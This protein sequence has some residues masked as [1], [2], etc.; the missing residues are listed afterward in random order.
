VE[1]PRWLA[2]QSRTEVFGPYSLKSINQNYSYVDGWRY[3][4]NEE[5]KKQDYVK[6]ADV[7]VE[8][9]VLRPVL[10]LNEHGALELALDWG[11]YN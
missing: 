4:Y 8:K 1:E 7:M 9:Q 6:Y 11:R 2:G 5:T 10:A 3:R